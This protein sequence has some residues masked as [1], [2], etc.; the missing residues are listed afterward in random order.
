MAQN[1]DSGL[2]KVRFSIGAKLIVIIT[3]IVLISLGTIITLASW[4]IREDLRLMAEDSN[5]E[6]N[7]RVAIATESALEY[8]HSNS[9]I[10][11]RTITKSNAG[12]NFEAESAEF[13]FERNPGIACVFFITHG[14]ERQAEILTNSDFFSS[15]NI[16]AGL[17]NEFRNLH[18]VS[19]LRSSAGETLLVNAAQN[20]GAPV[21]AMFFPW[22]NG[23]AGVVFSPTDLNDSYGYGVNQSYLINDLG[24]VLIH[25][26]FD[27]VRSGADMS[28]KRFTRHIW[29]SAERNAQILYTDEDGVTFFGAFTKLNT[30]GAIVITSVEYDKVFE[31]ID[32]T[33]RRNIYLAITV[34]SI[35]IILIWF[36]AKSISIPL[37]SLAIAARDIEDGI[38]KITLEPKSHDEIGVLTS[39]F[40]RMCK[41]L[42]IFGRFTNRDIAVRAMRGEIKPGGFL[43]KATIFFSDIRD[44]TSISEKITDSFGDDASDKIV[45]WLNNYFTQM[46][47]CVEKTNGVVDKFIGDALMAHWGTAYTT[48]KTRK[49]AYNC[50]KAALYMRSALSRMN[51]GRTKDNPENPPIRIGIGINTGTV[52]AG[53]LG[54]DMRMEYTV[55]GD[56][57]NLA[58]R[59]ESL[60]KEFGVDILIG[61]NTW[62]LVNKKFITVEMPSVTVKGKE[63]P[64]RLFAVINFAKNHK[65]PKS[66]TRL[67]RFLRIEP[68]ANLKLD[69]NSPEPKYIISGR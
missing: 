20:F 53:Q 12:I 67:R 26:D 52:T 49:D 14:Q 30:A 40:H 42:N 5:F 46:I 3:F 32:A 69:R 37:K 41:A 43:K 48:G 66:I 19:L 38:F 7:R 55:I 56:P 59:I 64:V 21:L 39:S 8:I 34:L 33:T 24:I 44:F 68:P 1:K 61:E 62:K 65:G 45:S 36:F 2:M 15:H 6:T 4:L 18:N 23:G 10:L 50:I 11:I 51:K 47:D 31:N 16:D 58:S 29:G 63:R 27:V 35:S 9:L 54:S 13:F 17:T 60:T 22:E 57:V 25:A 28:D